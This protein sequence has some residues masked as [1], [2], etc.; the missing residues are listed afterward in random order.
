MCPL[1]P[2]A[3]LC[4][5]SSSCWAPELLFELCA[6]SFLQSEALQKYACCSCSCG[7]ALPGCKAWPGCIQASHFCFSLHSCWRVGAAGASLHSRMQCTANSVRS[8]TQTAIFNSSASKPYHWVCYNV[9][10]QIPVVEFARDPSS[11]SPGILACHCIH[12]ALPDLQ[13]PRGTA[14][15]YFALAQVLYHPFLAPGAHI[16]RLPRHICICSSLYLACKVGT[17]F[18]LDGGGTTYHSRHQRQSKLTVIACLHVCYQ[19]VQPQ[20]NR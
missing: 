4:T 2:A 9:G 17:H 10:G 20:S 6:V 13:V 1:Q 16:K 12:T 15:T 7:N 5:A 3:A 18:K 8:T 19:R 11:V 14:R